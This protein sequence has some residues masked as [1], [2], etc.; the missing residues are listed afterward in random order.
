MSSPNQYESGLALNGLACFVTPDIA[1]DLANDVLTI[2]SIIISDNYMY[3]YNVYN[4][5]CFFTC[6]CTCICTFQIIHVD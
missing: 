4:I 5:F 1:R 2:V 3:M 6:I